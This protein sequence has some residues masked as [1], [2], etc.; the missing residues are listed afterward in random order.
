[1][2]K[3]YK[4]KKACNASYKS[5]KT[6]RFYRTIM[7]SK[8]LQQIDCITIRRFKQERKKQSGLKKHRKFMK[9]MKFWPTK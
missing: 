8:D 1:M 7:A 5:Q 9:F 2:S 4:F 6:L 3:N